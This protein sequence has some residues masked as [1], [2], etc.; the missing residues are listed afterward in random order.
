MLS[1]SGNLSLPAKLLVAV[2]SIVV[3]L[4]ATEGAVR[5]TG[6]DTFFQDRFFVLNHA[7]DYPDVF[8]KDH[9]LFWRMRPNHQG[10]S[11]FFDG[12]RYRLNSSGLRGPEIDPVKS[13]V[14]I[15]ALG[16]SCTYGWSVSDSDTY[17]ARLQASLGDRYEVINCGVPG[18]SS[19]QGRV[20]FQRE[21]L[22]LQPD[23]VLVMF[24][25]NDI[26]AA[27]G[28][29]ADKEQR[30]PPQ[31]ILNTQNVL[32]N[33]HTYRLMKKLLL[34]PIEQSPDS[35]FSRVAP[36]Y[37][38]EA[39]DFA[40]NLKAICDSAKAHGCRPILMT[41]PAA[42]LYLYYPPRARSRFH[43][44]HARYNDTTRA[45][46]AREHVGL[47]DLAVDFDQY[48]GLYDDAQRDPSH[49]N[50]RGHEYA[51]GIIARYLRDSL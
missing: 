14:R 48:G 31:F 15:L 23:I 35:L 6:V 12:K 38:V 37:R 10:T 49:F 41:G 43:A 50:A 29:I 42:S 7:L 26:W 16:N 46:A 11:R 30:F 40:A 45:V 21:L 32:S 24:G 39:A 3:F 36:V 9:D 51:A 1:D 25:W 28:E 18:Y 47:I 13:R 27:A 20:F 22:R 34:T 17:V 19:Y 2:G 33:L 5:L 4:L 8:M 44:V